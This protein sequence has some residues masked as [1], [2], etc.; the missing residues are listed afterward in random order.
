MIEFHYELEFELG[1]ESKFSDWISRIINSEGAHHSQI[2]FIF[3]S[4]AYLLEINLK[5][6]RHDTFTDIITFDYSDDTTVSGDVFISVDRVREN[7][8]VFGSTFEKEL[9]RVMSHGVLHL[10]GYTDKSD[11]DSAVMR[12]KEDEKITLFHVEH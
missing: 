4:D 9:L 6:L 1:N 2:D 3:C 12:N 10:L 8:A 7:A 5:Y 11:K